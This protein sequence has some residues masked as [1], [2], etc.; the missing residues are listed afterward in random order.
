MPT[1]NDANMARKFGTLMRN[2][3]GSKGAVSMGFAAG[4][5]V[6]AAVVVIFFPRLLRTRAMIIGKRAQ[7]TKQA[8]KQIGRKVQA[9]VRLTVSGGAKFGLAKSCGSVHF[10]IQQ[11]G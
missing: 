4:R 2:S 10:R 11:G 8:P 5:G 1:R 3:N 9:A 7:S 6:V